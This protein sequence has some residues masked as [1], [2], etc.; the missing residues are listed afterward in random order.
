MKTELKKYLSFILILSL[1]MVNCV[2][3]TN[4]SEYTQTGEKK[5]TTLQAHLSS[6][7]R[8]ED[9]LIA[10]KRVVFLLLLVAVLTVL[11]VSLR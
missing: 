5:G 10:V 2:T 7:N 9:N 8:A 6:G 1:L 4:I 3:V 11:S